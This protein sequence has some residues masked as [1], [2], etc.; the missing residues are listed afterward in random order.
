[1]CLDPAANLQENTEDRRKHVQ[2]PY[3]C[4]ISK[5]QPENAPGQTAQDLQQIKEQIKWRDGGG[6][7]AVLKGLKDTASF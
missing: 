5:I 1:M 2:E 3:D 4:A 6:E 7:I